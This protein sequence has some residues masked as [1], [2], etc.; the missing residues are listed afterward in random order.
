MI[1]LKD[2]RR[3]HVELTTRC[4]ARCPMCMRNYR[5]SDYNGGYPLCELSLEQFSSI[6]T[7]DI[8]QQI[9]QPDPPV[10]GVTPWIQSWRGVSF[11][12]NLGDFGLASDAA[13]IVQYLVDHETNVEINTNGSMRSPRWWA[14][15]AHPRVR[16]GFALDGLQDTHGLYRQDTDWHRVIENA[17]AFIEAGGIATWRFIPFDHNRHQ[18]QACRDLARELGFTHFENIY[19][20]RDTGPVFNRDGTYSHYL[21]RDTAE[22][23]Q[24]PDRESLLQNHITWFDHRT[25]KSHKD[26]A[27]LNLSCTHLMNREIYI[28][29][30][31]SVYPCC[32]L[33]FYPSTMTHPG[34]EQVRELLYQNN[35]LEHGLEAAMSWFDRVQQSWNRASLADGRLYACVNNCNRVAAT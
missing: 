1:Q 13:A 28:A 18:E 3:I 21:G 12:G 4:N 29:A 16:I 19:D 22:T 6:V 9:M 15:L 24:L 31:G 25:F 20:G 26:T 2:V 35:A 34:N 17:R 30:D 7:P 23:P 27:K 32:Y 14:Q 33:G 5:G 8:L 11:N 10:G